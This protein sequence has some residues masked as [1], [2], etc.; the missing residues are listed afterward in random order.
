MTASQ[1]FLPVTDIKNDLIFLD[2]GSVTAV[3]RTSAVNFGLLSEAEQVSIIES[4]A[5]LLN[6]LSF[7]IQIVIHSERL[8]V[9]SYLTLLDKA[10]ASQQNPLLKNLIPHYRSF[11]EKL[12]KENDV[13]DKQFYVAVNVTLPELGLT[14]HGIEDK[15]KK[16]TTILTP[17]LDHLNRQLSRIG[18]K[19]KRLNTEELIHFFYEAYNSVSINTSSVPTQI[20]QPAQPT[21]AQPQPVAIPRPVQPIAVQTAAPTIPRQVAPQP[22]PQPVY[23]HRAAPFV[24]EEL[25]DDFRP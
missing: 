24:V 17:R 11:V 2:D 7:A 16:A 22:A 1:D 21:Q 15:T 9:T 23:V 18:L 13:L 20:Q 19:E 14:S 3:T 5:G 8:D 12:I 6:S 4:F 25:A 10:F